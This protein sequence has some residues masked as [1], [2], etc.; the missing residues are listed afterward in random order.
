MK[1]STYNPVNMGL[2]LEDAT[3]VDF[4]GV[5]RGGYSSP[6]VVKPSISTENAFTQLALFL[7][8][9]AG[10]TGTTF[11]SYK[12]GYAVSGIGRGSSYLSDELIEHSGVSDFSEI[13][14]ISG[15]GQMMTASNPEYVWLDI[16]AGVSD[17]IGDS[18]INYRFVFEYS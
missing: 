1:I 8:D 18:N 14:T 11:R 17:T 2:I 5:V 13:S 6:V 16:K 7:E 15:D 9:N 4:G 12:N 3:G 10:L